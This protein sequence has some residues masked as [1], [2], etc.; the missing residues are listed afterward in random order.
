MAEAI[1]NR[2]AATIRDATLKMLEKLKTGGF[3]PKLHILDNECSELLKSA[4]QKHK[5]TFQLV[6]PHQKHR[7]AAERAIQTFKNH[8]ITCLCL[9]DPNFPLSEWDRLLCQCLISLNHLRAS[10]VNPKLSAYASLEGIFDF[11]KTPMA[12]LG[13]KLVYH[14]K[15]DQRS[16]FDVRGKEAWYV[17]PA[18]EH[19]RCV[20]IFIP[21]TRREIQV[22]TVQYFPN[23]VPIPATSK[24][25][26]LL[27]S[28]LDMLELLKD[29][30]PAMPAL[31]YSHLDKAS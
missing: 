20:S 28:A 22:D 26:L 11:N 6:P 5:I 1:P 3:V 25:S 4:F 30:T 19:Y 17:G 14:I 12:P 7:N 29:P 21:E 31:D 8:F 27:K 24:E 15:P 2:Q 16:T 13:T 18:T 9:L 10:R 23:K